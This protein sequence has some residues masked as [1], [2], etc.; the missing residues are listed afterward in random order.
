VS[1]WQTDRLGNVYVAD[2][3]NS[4]IR[5]GTPLTL[6]IQSLAAP[7]QVAISWPLL[8]TGFVLEASASPVPTAW[9]PLSNGITVSGEN[10]VLTTNASSLSS[11]YR[12]RR[13]Q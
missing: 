12:L 8:A 1:L 2:T 10:F 13:S 9:T 11:F 7:H 5:R 6:S 4:T 3:Q